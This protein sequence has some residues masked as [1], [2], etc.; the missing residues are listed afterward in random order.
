MLHFCYTQDLFATLI[1]L[2]YKEKNVLLLEVIV[3]FPIY[4]PPF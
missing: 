4:L 1:L 2:D 3:Y